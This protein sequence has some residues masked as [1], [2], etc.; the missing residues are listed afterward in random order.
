VSAKDLNI[1]H[2]MW[3]I[4]FLLSETMTV[5]SH[6]ARV[7]TT[8]A[9]DLKMVG[10]WMH[11]SHDHKNC[12]LMLV[13]FITSLP[14]STT[15]LNISLIFQ[16]P[17]NIFHHHGLYACTYRDH[18]FEETTVRFL[19]SPILPCSPLVHMYFPYTSVPSPG[20]TLKGWWLSHS[21]SNDFP[22]VDPLIVIDSPCPPPLV[23]QL[24]WDWSAWHYGTLC[25][26]VD[27]HLW[28][29]WW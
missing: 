20:T 5:P 17:F 10:V 1:G 19:T 13:F 8:I 26:H 22:E 14:S 21:K 9:A 3:Y 27:T 15:S 6:A 2:C 28:E 29:A 7:D 11:C 12:R 24:H 18:C 25:R 23:P 16:Q 4:I